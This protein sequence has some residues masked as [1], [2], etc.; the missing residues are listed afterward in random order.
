M[1][2]WGNPRPP[3]LQPQALCL[4][5]RVSGGAATARRH[6]DSRGGQGVLALSGAAETTGTWVAG[7]AGGQVPPSG[8]RPGPLR[9]SELGAGQAARPRHLGPRLSQEAPGLPQCHADPGSSW[10]TPASGGT[11]SEG[12]GLADPRGQARLAE[13]GLPQALPRRPD[14]CQVWVLSAP[15]PGLQ[16]PLP[17]A[18]ATFTVSL[19]Q[20]PGHLDPGTIQWLQG[21]ALSSL[22]LL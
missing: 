15:H 19:G 11:R 12:G 9:R 3:A 17:Q 8:T 4:Q 5:T 16:Q 21:G 14:L 7:C 22:G 2:P 13:G 20:P 1:C 10:Q 6:Q 18:L